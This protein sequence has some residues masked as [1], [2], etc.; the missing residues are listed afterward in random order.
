MDWVDWMGGWISYYLGEDSVGVGAGGGGLDGGTGDPEMF[1]VA[2]L[3]G[4]PWKRVLSCSR[5][6]S[7]SR[8]ILPHR[9][10]KGIFLGFINLH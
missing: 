1:S 8:A 5:M 3:D 10:I 7:G 9:V 6:D 2:V 4:S